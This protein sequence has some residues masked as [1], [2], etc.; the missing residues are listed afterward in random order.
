MNLPWF[1]NANE[2]RF[3]ENQ[4]TFYTKLFK[5]PSSMPFQMITNDIYYL[6]S[7]NKTLLQKKIKSVAQNNSNKKLCCFTETIFL[8]KLVVT[9]THLRFQGLCFVKFQ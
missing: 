6:E 9:N 4:R 1:E 2:K 5:D 3:Y 8:T 7:L